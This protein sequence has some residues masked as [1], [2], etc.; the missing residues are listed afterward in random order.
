[1]RQRQPRAGSLFVSAPLAILFLAALTATPAARAQNGPPTT[2]PVAA[3]GS[4]PNIPRAYVSADAPVDESPLPPPPQ[5][6]TAIQ[7]EST[8]ITTPPS[9]N[10]SFPLTPTTG[11]LFG[12]WLGALPYLENHGVTPSLNFTSDM[13]GNPT[14]GLRH[15]FTAA[16]NL[17][18]GLLFDADKL[19]GIPGGSFLVHVSERFGPSLTKKDLGNAFN[20]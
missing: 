9:V 7:L 2:P 8:G 3:P 17:G 18:L 13:A 5:E 11:H 12:D 10:R 14:G 6:P 1:V 20:V 15:G 4:V 16:N 19:A